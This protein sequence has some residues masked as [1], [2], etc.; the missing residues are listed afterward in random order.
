MDKIIITGM[1]LSL[2]AAFTPA[3]DS[4]Q[5]A[6]QYP[7]LVQQAAPPAQQAP[8]GIVEIGS[9]IVKLKGKLTEAGKAVQGNEA[10][11]CDLYLEAL[12]RIDYFHQHLEKNPN[13]PMAA[14]LYSIC[15]LSVEAALLQLEEK[16]RTSQILRARDERDSI[17]TELN[18]LHIK[19]TDI[20][21]SYGTKLQ[22]DLLEEKKKKDSALEETR[23]LKADAEARFDELKSALIQ[24]KRDARGLIISMSDILFAF[25]KADLTPELKTSLAKMAGILLVYKKS[26]IQVEGHTDNKGTKDY[27]QK[28]SEKRAQNVMDY[29][30]EQGIKPLRLKSVGYGQTKPIAT[31]T[32][33]EGRQQNRR[34]DLIIKDDETL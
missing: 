2:L 18:N 20:E 32:T 17:L 29:L 13:D 30:V 7:P 25:D 27:N 34:V 14:D 21:R 33:K 3:Q 1:A 4:T 8:A 31:N 10:L 5:P 16:T 26:R 15:S 6:P 28:L 24:V 11:S 22:A 19:I 9:N 12:A 23:K